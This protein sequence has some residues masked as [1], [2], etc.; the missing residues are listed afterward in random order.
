MDI[1]PNKVARVIVRARELG[2]KVARWD[3]PS[4]DADAETILEER[5][6]DATA[7]ELRSYISDLN[8]DEK[9]ALVALMWIGRDTFSADEYDEAFQTA[10][11]EASAPTED[12]LM[13]VPLLADYLES[14]LEALGYD[15]SDEEDDVFRG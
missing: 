15:P 4:D 3:A 9:S 2:V 11:D 8:D 10:K 1:S 13:G 12:Y 14:G 7:R 5:A 6:S